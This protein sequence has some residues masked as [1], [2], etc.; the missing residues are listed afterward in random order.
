M[1]CF[2]GGKSEGKSPLGKPRHKWEDN[3]KMCL[4][5][6]GWE[7]ADLVDLAQDRHK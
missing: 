1:Q 6:V 5:E 3:V 2:G 4:K 7:V